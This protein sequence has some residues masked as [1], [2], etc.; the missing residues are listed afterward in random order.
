MK[1]VFIILHYMAEEETYRSVRS[2][3]EKIDVEEYRIII[4]D[5]GSP[6]GSGQRLKNLYTSE[7]K[8]KVVLTGE[9]LGFAR[10]NN[11]GFKYAKDKWNPDYI[12][13]MN[14]D[15]YLLD[16]DLVE[17]IEREFEKSAFAVAGPMIMTADGRCNINPISTSLFSKKAIEQELRIY[18]RKLFLCK[19]HLWTLRNIYRKFNPLLKRREDKN[20]IFRYDHVQLH[21]CFMIFSKVYTEKFDGLDNRTFLYREEAILYKHLCENNMNS[22]YVPDIHVFHR[23]DASTNIVVKKSRDKALFEIKN[24]LKS[25][26]VL[27]EVYESY[28]KTDRRKT[29]EQ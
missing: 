21:G 4:V 23:E 29:N 25:L 24:H 10:G 22:V 12:I 5:N 2:I 27:L 19:Y 20:F 13:L 17:K 11:I 15:V 8:I 28:E 3:Q 1:I 6:D 7:Q 14:N 26:G 16:D 18:K 9:N